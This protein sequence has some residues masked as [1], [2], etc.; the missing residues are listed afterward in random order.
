MYFSPYH[1]LL[2]NLTLSAILTGLIWTIQIV[3]YPS[4]L[5]VG[6]DQ[7]LV[8]QQNHMKNISF[9]VGP[10]MI[11]EL[12]AGVYLLF[13]QFSSGLHWLILLGSLLLLII[14]VVTIFVA[15]PLHARLVSNGYE[16]QQIQKLINVNWIRTVAWSG[17]TG[18][19]FYLLLGK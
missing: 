18:I 11:L 10:L 17:R 6:T 8:F 15:S 2:I 5:D 13:D 7:Y 19:F 1:L 16:V 4:F 12:G 3:H 14:W 9:L